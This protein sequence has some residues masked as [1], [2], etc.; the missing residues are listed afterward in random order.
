MADIRGE[1]VSFG[2]DDIVALH[3]LPSAKAHEPIIVHAP[4]G[5]G[6]LSFCIRA[7][8]AAA[9]LVVLVLGTAIVAI[10]TGMVDA[11]LNQRAS[12]ALNAALGEDYAA[13]VGSTVLRVTSRADL[14]LEARDVSLADRRSGASLV[15]AQSISI[16]LDPF[17]LLTGHVAVSRLEA[18]GATLDPALMPKGRAID[19]TALKVDAVPEALDSVFAEIDR[20]ARIVASSQTAAVEIS[21][22]SLSLAGP[23]GTTVALVIDRLAFQRS[24]QG[25]MHITGAVTV[26]GAEARL[27]L[28]AAGEGA[29]IARLA[30][31]VEGVPLSPFTHRA[32][33]ATEAAFGIDATAAV[34]LSA[35]RGSAEHAPALAVTLKTS[36]G[37]FDAGGLSSALNPSELRLGY[38]FDRGA[39]E[40]LPSVVNVGRSTF[41]V[42]GSLVDRAAVDGAPGVTIDLL[43]SGARVAPVDVSDPP[44]AFDAKA[45]GS[46]LVADHRL[47]FDQLRISSP[48]GAMAGSLAIAFADTSP[49]ISFVGL[50]DTM[51]SSAVKQLW[52]WWVGRNARRWVVANIF[53]GTVRNGRIEVVIDK[54]RL[55]N[56][57]GPVELTDEE[58]KISFDID[59]TRVNLAGD[60]PPLRDAGGSFLLTGERMD[61]A[62]RKGTA[63]F[64][65]GRTVRLDDGDFAIPDIHAKPL[66]AEMK[67]HVAGEAD[68]LAELASYRPIAALQ[69]TP[70]RPEDFSGPMTAA[71]GAYFGL[72]SA[73]KPPKPQWQA[74]LM[75]NGVA[76]TRPL[77]GRSITDLDGRLR[78]D[79]DKAELE[80]KATVDGAPLDVTLVEPVGEDSTAVRRRS[81]RG[82]L[83]AAALARFAPG[84]NGIVDGP[85]DVAVEFGADGRQSV[86]AGLGKAE[87]NLPWVGWTK[88]SGIAA[89]VRFVVQ[90]TGEATRISDFSLSGDGFGASG[91]LRLD[92]NGLADARLQ[93]VR[94]APGDDFS[95]SL[96]RGGRGF[97]VS[98]KGAQADLRPVLAKLKDGDDAR[99]GGGTSTTVRADLDRVIGF[100]GE[101][102]GNVAL[103]YAT[104]GPL[105]DTLDLS[106]VLEGGQALVAKLVKE[107]GDPVVELAA[108]NAGALA[109]FSGLYENMRGG[110][111]NLRLRDR[112]AGSWRGGIEV[113]KFSL[114]NEAR[115]QS[116][117]STPA[118]SSG[119]S[120]NDAVRRDIDVSTASFDR[121]AAQLMLDKGTVRLDRG[122]LRGTEIGATFQG[123]LRDASGRMDMTG[124]FM[125]A[126]GLNRLFA[127][128]PLIGTILGNGRDRGLLGITFKLTGPIA[129]PQLTINPLSI[130]A[131]GVFRSIFEF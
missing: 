61:V 109:R 41:P 77:E 52:P 80:A 105:I 29:R 117:V 35:E 56:T 26:D 21:D 39:I 13:T 12:R 64:P 73:Q 19:L 2:R 63:F 122:V 45:T 1:K 68:A 93:S 119:R 50:I 92:G 116:I 94:L 66:M 4:E 24:D 121:G 22:T 62:I 47:V 65:S 104:R 5:R 82:T 9:C 98:V 83:G 81:A 84:L 72:I 130:I 113:R 25:A 57:A 43:V 3:D 128:L 60:I 70:F 8:I 129:R 74:E 126:Y 40:I 106:A 101:A 127:E 15:T 28:T 31:S 23:R 10:E 54:G 6:P 120:L 100:N 36:S 33:T 107:G 103:S 75:L 118:D 53:G 16:V 78:V 30:G 37:V 11:A 89:T 114:V 58:L 102:V 111:L 124:T 85:V 20:I 49:R 32:G 112:G 7:A 125:P 79:T 42:T 110:L 87:V 108:G 123:T 48:R 44:L 67:L 115:L 27:D 71:I 17:A 18:S 14:A 131:P 55:A 96:E 95:V 86:E 51:E 59:D 69:R 90:K 76:L 91:D 38:D 88:G 99:A 34:T 46:F 97:S